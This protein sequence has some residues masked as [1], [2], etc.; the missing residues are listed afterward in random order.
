M[1]NDQRAFYTEVVRT[2]GVS[3]RT[4]DS[5]ERDLP[6]EKLLALG[7]RLG[8]ECCLKHTATQDACYTSTWS[9]CKSCAKRAR[10]LP[11]VPA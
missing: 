1:P 7:V 4:S 2:A 11:W 9:V 6:V 10:T 5:I 8:C 3:R